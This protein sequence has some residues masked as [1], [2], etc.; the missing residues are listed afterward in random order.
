[1]NIEFYKYLKVGDA[2]LVRG[3]QPIYRA[4][5]GEV[6]TVRET[7]VIAKITPSGQ[8]VL[9]N[10]RRFRANGIEVGNSPGT[11]VTVRLYPADYDERVAADQGYNRLRCY[12]HCR[13]TRGVL[14][15]EVIRQLVTL[16]SEAD[17]IEWAKYSG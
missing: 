3:T 14:G 16:L 11:A 9:D 5:G 8:I 13:Y 6:E 12:F 15:P 2:V 7:A 10:G 1:M 4:R 17:P